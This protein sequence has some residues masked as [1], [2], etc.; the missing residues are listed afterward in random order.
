MDDSPLVY[1][2]TYK[3]DN[4]MDF[5]IQFLIEMGWQCDATINLDV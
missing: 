5:G 4:K 2:V 1:V 3:G